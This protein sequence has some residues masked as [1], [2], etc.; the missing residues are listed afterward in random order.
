MNWSQ[1]VDS[2][3]DKIRLNCIQLTNRHIKNHL[4]YKGASAYFEIPTIILSVFSGSF[5]VGSD[6]L[7]QQELISIIT[8]SISMV[9]TILTSVKL[10]MKITENSTQEQELAISFKSLALDIFKFLSLRNEDRGID[11][12]VYLNKVYGKYINLVENSSILNVMNKKDALL[13]ID[14]K[15]LN[16]NDDDSLSTNSSN[17]HNE[18][19]TPSP[20]TLSIDK[21]VNPLSITINE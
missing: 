14:P 18:D 10:Y 8:C 15:L 17:N 9:I 13:V 7:L 3:L 20:R 16:H 6:V 11:G 4:Y 19:L 12:L 21:R 2:L 5:S 1:S